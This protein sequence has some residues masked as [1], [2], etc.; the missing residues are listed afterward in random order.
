[1]FPQ[2]ESPVAF[3]DNPAQRRLSLVGLAPDSSDRL[4]SAAF[5]ADEKFIAGAQSRRRKTDKFLN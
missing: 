3:P 2:K 5:R 1:M 4:K